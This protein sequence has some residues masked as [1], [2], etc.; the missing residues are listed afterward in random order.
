VIVDLRPSLIPPGSHITS[1]SKFGHEMIARGRAVD[2][3]EL[4]STTEPGGPRRFIGL[5]EASERY[6][7]CAIT[8]PVNQEHAAEV[9]DRD[10]VILPTISGTRCTG[11]RS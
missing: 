9:I 3:T 10:D 5:A 4:V 11:L 8:P 2:G 6:R 7:F 1:E